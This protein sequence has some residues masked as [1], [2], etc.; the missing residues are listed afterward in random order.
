MGAIEIVLAILQTLTQLQPLA[1]EVEPIMAKVIQ[2]KSISDAE[3]AS[4]AAAASALNAEVASAAKAG[5]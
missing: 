5:G 3:L 1:A 2:G 4:L